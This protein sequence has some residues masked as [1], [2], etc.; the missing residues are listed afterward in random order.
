MRLDLVVGREAV[1]DYAAHFAQGFKD[2]AVEYVLAVRTVEAFD[3]AALHRL[4]RLD[5]SPLDAMQTDPLLDLVADRFRTIVHA[6]TGGG[7]SLT[8]N[9]RNDVL[10]LTFFE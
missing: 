4:A 2:V 3:Q 9:K 5:E 6:Q 8:L 10:N 1:G 7:P